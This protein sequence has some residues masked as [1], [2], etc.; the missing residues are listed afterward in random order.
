MGGGWFGGWL[1]VWC[2][3]VGPRPGEG[4]GDEVGGACGKVDL[5]LG[6]GVACCALAAAVTAA[7]MPAVLVRPWQGGMVGRALRS[8]VAMVTGQGSLVL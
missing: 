7:V 5:A 8:L 2:G 3:C 6:C 4:D 1:W